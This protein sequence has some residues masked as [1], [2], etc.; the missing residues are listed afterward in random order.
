M[1]TPAVRPLIPATSRER[2]HARASGKEAGRRRPQLSPVDARSIRLARPQPTIS[3]ALSDRNFHDLLPDRAAAVAGSLMPRPAAWR[4]FMIAASYVFYGWWD[5]HF[6]FLLA[7]STV[8]NYAVAI[9]IFRSRRSRA[10]RALLAARGRRRPRPARVLQVLR[11]LRQLRP[12]MRSRG[13]GSAC[14]SRRARSC[15]RSASPSSRSW[16]SATSSTSTAASSS[17][18]TLG[19]LRRLPLVL[20][21]PRR[22]AD[23]ARAAS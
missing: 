16:R 3:R 5:W 20:P 7:G 23:R 1:R 21:A 2:P 19:R 14:R 11:L 10:R 15:C 13:S 22:R 8:W 9:A 18:S 6:V 4:V 12:T 17:R